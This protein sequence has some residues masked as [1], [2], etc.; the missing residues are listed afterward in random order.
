M[1]RQTVQLSSHEQRGAWSPSK[2]EGAK[3]HSSLKLPRKNIP[4][5]AAFKPAAFRTTKE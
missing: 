1:W 3:S 5:D 4:A 2:Q